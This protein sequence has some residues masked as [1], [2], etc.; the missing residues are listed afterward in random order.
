MLYQLSYT[1]KPG[2]ARFK[3]RRPPANAECAGAGAVGARGRGRSAGIYPR[4]PPGATG[5]QRGYAVTKQ[6]TPVSDCSIQI[7]RISGVRPFGV[8]MTPSTAN[9]WPKA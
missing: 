1:P 2:G 7:V 5:L 9:F 3:E 6:G 8:G 4:G